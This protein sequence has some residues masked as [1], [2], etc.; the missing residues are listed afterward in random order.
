MD[1]HHTDAKE[2]N[3]TPQ[4]VK[5]LKETLDFPVVTSNTTVSHVEGRYKVYKRRFFGLAQLVL[6]NI[7]VSWDVCKS[8]ETLHASPPLR[9]FETISTNL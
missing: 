3:D 6:L 1:L 2:Q 4:E 5:S 7:V 9:L 8:N